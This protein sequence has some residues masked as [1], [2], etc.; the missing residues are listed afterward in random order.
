MNWFLKF[1]I[2]SIV[3]CVVIVFFVACV[4]EIEVKREYDV[5]KIK[6]TF[7]ETLR[8]MIPYAIPF[9]NVIFVLPLLLSYDN[10]KRQFILKGLADGTLKEKD[11]E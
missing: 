2:A 11:Y 4:M 5:A 1:W 6:R 10:M 8:A 7:A 9:L 3:G